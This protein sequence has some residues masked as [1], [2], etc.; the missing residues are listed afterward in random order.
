MTNHFIFTIGLHEKNSLGYDLNGGTAIC[1]IH[2][3]DEF[4]LNQ[5][6]RLFFEHLLDMG[7]LSDIVMDNKRHKFKFVYTRVD[8][9]FCIDVVGSFT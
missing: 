5:D 2:S 4:I 3:E 9:L 8:D 1:H 6:Q 7:L